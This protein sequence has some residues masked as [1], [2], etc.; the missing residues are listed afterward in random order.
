M[1]NA[2]GL[3]A[4]SFGP[5][6]VAVTTN[7]MK[8][9]SGPAC[10]YDLPS[11]D[12]SNLHS[13][14]LRPFGVLLHLDGDLSPPA[15]FSSTASKEAWGSGSVNGC[16]LQLDAENLT[17]ITSLSGHSYCRLCIKDRGLA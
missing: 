9:P 4:V 14:W 2:L 13:S 1:A 8:N 5:R 3:G 7:V 6:A 16:V 10:R 17:M 12:Y 15:A 11:I